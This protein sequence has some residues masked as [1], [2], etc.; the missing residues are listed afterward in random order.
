MEEE[1]RGT[2]R[3]NSK[4]FAAAMVAAIAEAGASF[5]PDW[6]FSFWAGGGLLGVFTNTPTP[7]EAGS[8]S[9]FHS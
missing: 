8:A 7:G 1:N 5:L 2:Q 3:V 9:G 4:T 6:G